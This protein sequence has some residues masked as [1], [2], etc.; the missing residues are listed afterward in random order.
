[1]FA[2]ISTLAY[3]P[4]YITYSVILFEEGHFSL[5]I[6][7]VFILFLFYRKG[8]SRLSSLSLFSSS[9]SLERIAL[10][11]KCHN[12]YRFS[13]CSVELH[14]LR[15]LKTVRTRTSVQTQ[16]CK[17]SNKQASARNWCTLKEKTL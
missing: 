12:A 5:L 14:Y 4:H 11:K 2:H 3:T 9:L 17:Y 1:M 15:Q 16:E 6:S 13:L 10:H 7:S 8:S